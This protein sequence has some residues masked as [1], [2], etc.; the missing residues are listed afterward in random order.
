MAMMQPLQN[1]GELWHQADD[2]RPSWPCPLEDLASP[3]A[4]RLAE[5][6]EAA[7]KQAVGDS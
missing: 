2:D 4:K 1:R 7:K 3:Q 5:I 6:I